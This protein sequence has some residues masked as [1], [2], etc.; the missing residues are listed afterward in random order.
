MLRCRCPIL[1]RTTPFLFCV[2]APLISSH[3]T[4]AMIDGQWTFVDDQTVIDIAPCAAQ[5]DSFCAT[6]ARLPSS[7]QH[8]APSAR[9][10]LCRAHVLGDLRAQ[11]A[12]DSNPS[13]YR[14]W[15]SDPEDLLNEA[16]PPR[17]EATLMLT[18]PARAVIDVRV[19]DGLYSERHDLVRTVAPVQPC[20]LR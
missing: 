17:Y 6:M 5:A 8:L 1:R 2:I 16:S 18:S 15:I 20:G 13:I 4:A 12:G 9:S 14:G 10:T 11:G 7:A 3:A 19:A